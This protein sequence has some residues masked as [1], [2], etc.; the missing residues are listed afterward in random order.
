MAI[1]HSVVK[2]GKRDRRFD[3]RTLT[4]S[5]Y[6][7]LSTI[8]EPPETCDNTRGVTDFGMMGNDKL[9]DCTIA[10]IAHAVQIAV[11]SQVDAGLRAKPVMPD[12]QTVIDHYSRWCGY[13]PGDDS[14]DHGGV[15]LEVLKHL[16]K[17]GFEGRKFLAFVQVDP[18]DVHALNLA[19]FM[20][21]FVYWGIALPDGWAGAPL[22]DASMG[23]PGSWGGHCVISAQYSAKRRPVI[24]WGEIQEATVNGISQYADE[25][26]AIIAEDAI[27]PRGFDKERLVDDLA[28]VKR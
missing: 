23:A 1:D 20:F 27:P 10:G 7:N 3:R 6:V 25:A 17:E 4:M 2:L 24:T 13:V 18:T 14:T 5:R 19:T 26:Y 9:G 12:T 22:W 11:L 15:E 21:G 28:W 8:P 16:V